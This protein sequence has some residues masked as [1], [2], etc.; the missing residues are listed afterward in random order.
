MK[1]ELTKTQ[2]VNEGLVI[3]KRLSSFITM[4]LKR[5]PLSLSMFLIY[6]LYEAFIP[7]INAYLLKVIVD[8]VIL[9]SD[10]LH[11]LLNVILIPAALFVCAQILMNIIFSLYRY[12]QLKFYP[13]IKSDIAGTI[14]HY[15]LQHISLF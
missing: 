14:L 11:F 12:A 5:H 6:I 2:I 3:P 9:T 10:Q 4:F 15:L 13:K 8:G 1:V 7:L